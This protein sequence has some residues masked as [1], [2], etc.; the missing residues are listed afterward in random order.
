MLTLTL[1]LTLTLK[2]HSFKKKDRPR[3]L[4][5]PLAFIGKNSQRQIILKFILQWQ[6]AKNHLCTSLR[7]KRFQ[8]SYCAKVRAGAKKKVEG[9][10]WRGGGEKRFP[11]FPSPSLVIPFFCSCPSFSRWTRAETLATQA[12]CAR[13]KKLDN[14]NLVT[15]RH[16]KR[17]K[18]LRPVDARRLKQQ[19]QQNFIDK[20][21]KLQKYYP[22]LAR[23]LEAGPYGCKI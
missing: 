17:E 8:S 13:F 3:V 16:I 7:S 14:T 12:T 11:S 18:A 1:T 6:E 10:R 4:L 9:G 5:T 23:I 21:I 20:Q 22:Q 19:Q 15:S 2:Q